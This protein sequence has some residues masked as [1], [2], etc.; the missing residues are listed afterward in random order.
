MTSASSLLSLGSGGLYS[1][2]DPRTDAVDPDA[3]LGVLQVPVSHAT[4]S[5]LEMCATHIY[6]IA[7]RQTDNS[8][9]RSTIR[10]CEGIRQLK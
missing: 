1:R 7:L 8:C 10:S 2:D 4:F 3:I 5:G 9:F 6:R